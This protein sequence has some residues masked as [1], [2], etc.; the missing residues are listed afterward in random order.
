MKTI[1]GLL[2]AL[3]AITGCGSDGSD[4]ADSTPDMM[5]MGNSVDATSPAPDSGTSRDVD[6]AIMADADSSA[7]RE[8]VDLD[9]G[10]PQAYVEPA[11]LGAGADEPD[12]GQRPGCN[13]STVSRIRG[14]IVDRIGRPVGDA[15]AQ[16]C[17]VGADGVTNCLRPSDS[18][19]DGVF[20]IDIGEEYQCLNTAAFRLIKPGSG[21]APMYCNADLPAPGSDTRLVLNEPFVLYAGIPAAILP[22]AGDEMMSRT[23]TFA[24]GVELDIAPF[25]LVSPYAEL[26]MRTVG[27]DE[28]GLCFLEGQ[29]AP[30]RLY[31]FTPDSTIYGEASIRFPNETELSPGAKVDISILGGLGCERNGEHVAEGAWTS[32]GTGTV[33]ESG[34]MIV[35]DEGAVLTCLTW[36]GYTPVP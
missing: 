2:V 21:R 24:N 19:P 3:L 17:I 9:E 11:T 30:T 33:N 7:P 28:R 15:K 20:N 8:G 22:P 16:L 27:A 5:A 36:I 4:A 6:A 10:E 26:G 14:W 32:I 34:A 12:P 25:D 35:G 31:A 18:T 23:V 29:T 1:I 13:G